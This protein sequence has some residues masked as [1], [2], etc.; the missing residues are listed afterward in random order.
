[1]GKPLLKQHP[2]ALGREPQPSQR[3][4]Q[5]EAPLPWCHPH[6]SSGERPCHRRHRQ[7]VLEARAGGQHDRANGPVAVLQLGKSCPHLSS[8][9]HGGIE[10]QTTPHTH[11]RHPDRHCHV[12]HPLELLETPDLAWDQFAHQGAAASVGV[13]RQ[14][15]PPGPALICA[16][17]SL[18]SAGELVHLRPAAPS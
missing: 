9:W 3:Q 17:R 16:R 7:L 6:L 12:K 2:G 15:R 8:G 14:Q 4:R 13:E 10:Q 1:M 11:H 18:I 5:G